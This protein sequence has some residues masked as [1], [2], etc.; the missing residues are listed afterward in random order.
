MSLGPRD[1]CR[2][3]FAATTSGFAATP[4][5]QQVVKEVGLGQILREEV[6][7]GRQRKSRRVVAEPDLRLLRVVAAPEQ[8]RS[9]GGGSSS[10]RK[11]RF[12]GPFVVP[13]KGLEPL[14]PQRGHLI[15]SQARMTSF[16]TPA[17]R[18]IAPGGDQER[19]SE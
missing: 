11:G 14:R 12:S 7:V 16:A 5:Q 9:A 17:R 2:S 10:T 1:A 13:G 18:R 8:D 4:E 15:L 6:N 3:G 19:L